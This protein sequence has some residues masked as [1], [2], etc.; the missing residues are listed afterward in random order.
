MFY[1][2]VG[3]GGGSEREYLIMHLRVDIVSPATG[4]VIFTSSYSSSPDGL[5]GEDVQAIIVE[6]KNTKRRWENIFGEGWVRLTLENF[7][8]SVF[9]ALLLFRPLLF[10]ERHPLF[11]RQESVYSIIQRGLGSE[12]VKTD[13]GLVFDEKRQWLTVVWQEARRELGVCADFEACPTWRKILLDYKK[14]LGKVADWEYWKICAEMMGWLVPQYVLEGLAYK[15]NVLWPKWGKMRKY[16]DVTVMNLTG[17][18]L[19]MIEGA[20]KGYIDEVKLLPGRRVKYAHHY[21][22]EED[23]DEFRKVN[24]VLF[25]EKTRDVRLARSREDSKKRRNAEREKRAALKTGEDRYW[26]QATRELCTLATA[27]GTPYPSRYPDLLSGHAA[28]EW[29]TR[30][31]DRVR[32]GLVHPS[33]GRVNGL[34]RKLESLA[35]ME[36]VP[37][38]FSLWLMWRN[39]GKEALSFYERETG[40][41]DVSDS[42]EIASEGSHN[43]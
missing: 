1:G 18:E 6:L 5:D 32:S 27:V 41:N 7:E 3:G 8:A 31:V 26:H 20:D 19:M 35:T 10:S 42:D 17:M 28:E 13:L 40:G 22:K 25:L 23:K 38:E 37:A 9:W 39:K 24:R 12:L 2:N 16:S 11:E 21:I 30:A 15:K 29:F 33:W 36:K 43:V 14:R 4:R 34:V